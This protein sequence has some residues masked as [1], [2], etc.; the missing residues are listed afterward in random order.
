MSSKEYNKKWR[1]AHKEELALKKKQWY[2]ANKTEEHKRGISE[3]MKAYWV[4]KREQQ[5]W[6]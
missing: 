2:E 1:E 5:K 6:Q 3:G 4:R